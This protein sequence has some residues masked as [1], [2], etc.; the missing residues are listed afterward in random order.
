ME[1]NEEIIVYKRTSFGRRFAAL[2]ID[3]VIIYGLGY[4]LK[5]I[6]GAPTPLA[7]EEL[8]GMPIGEMM[9]KSMAVDMMPYYVGLTYALME[10][11]LQKSPGKMILGLVIADQE[12]EKPEMS[13][14]VLRY[15]LKQGA[16]IL[17]LI[18]VFAQISMFIW[19]G[20]FLSFVFV[21]G[22]L[23]AMSEKRLALHDI[24]AKTAVYNEKMLTE[25]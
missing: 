9:L 15:F 2:V 12:G 5:L 6:L 16:Y 20:F 10:I 24:I 3:G 13:A 23:A 18:A 7:P 22:G 25:E 14:M 8:M 17:F 1:E 19:A 21:L 4:V 11:F